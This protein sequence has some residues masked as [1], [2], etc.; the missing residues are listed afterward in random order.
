MRC[1]LDVRTLIHMEQ[2]PDGS[3]VFNC[4]RCGRSYK[5]STS[6]YKHLR[7]ECGIEPRFKCHLCPYR[8]KQAGNMRIHIRKKHPSEMLSDQ[9]FRCSTLNVPE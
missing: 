5:H 1:C 7:Y 2:R 3:T 9:D 4:K 8:A 6:I